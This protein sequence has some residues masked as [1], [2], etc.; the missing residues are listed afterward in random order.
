LTYEFERTDLDD[1]QVLRMG[2][3]WHF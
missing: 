3:T 1:F 2:F